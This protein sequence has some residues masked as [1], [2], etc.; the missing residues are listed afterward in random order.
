MKKIGIFTWEYE[1]K[2]KRVVRKYKRKGLHGY[3]RTVPEK[4]ISK[5]LDNTKILHPKVYRD[6]IKYIDEEFIENNQNIEEIDKEKLVNTIIFYMTEM[7]NVNCKKINKFIKW[8]NNSEFLKFQVENIKRVL[9]D[10]KCNVLNENMKAL[11]EF[12][13]NLD[14]NRKLSLIHGDIHLNNMIINNN[15]LYFIDWELATYGD[16]AYELAMHFILMKYNEIEKN[17]FINK[18]C[19]NISINKQNLINDIKIYEKFEMLR[20]NILQTIHRNE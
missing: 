1:S 5:L 19:E 13:I 16:I 20:K 15:G 12:M 10:R 3:P 6:R 17:K 7:N 4:Y 11:D 14:N 18:L 8:K 2:N 9:I